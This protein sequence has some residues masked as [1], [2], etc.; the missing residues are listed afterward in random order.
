MRPVENPEVHEEEWIKAFDALFDN[1]DL[2]VSTQYRELLPVE[3]R[4]IIGYNV[5][6]RGLYF[7]HGLKRMR[8]FIACCIWVALGLSIALHVAKKTDPGTGFTIGAFIIAIPALL[9]AVLA[10]GADTETS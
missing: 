6:F 10:L 4:E 5:H 9:V 8:V 3:H 1:I 7:T 2:L